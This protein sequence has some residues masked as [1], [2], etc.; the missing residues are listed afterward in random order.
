M[1]NFHIFIMSTRFQEIST[2]DMNSHFRLGRSICRS[3]EGWRSWQQMGF[4]LFIIDMW[5]LQGGGGHSLAAFAG[6]LCSSEG[7]AGKA[8]SQ[9]EISKGLRN[10]SVEQAL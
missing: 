7:K 8:I 5:S 3:R 2:L 4:L 1:F 10:C 9:I 6:L